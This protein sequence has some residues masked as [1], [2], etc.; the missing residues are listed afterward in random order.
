MVRVRPETREDEAGVR[1]RNLAAFPTAQEADLVEAL[2]RDGDCALG[3]PDYYRRFGFSVEAA[4][5]FAS[6]YA[7]PYFQAL[8]LA[9]DAP[10]A[11]RVS[12]PAAFDGL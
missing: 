9:P 7:G 8:M 2:R 10:K 1:E 5:A 3:E 4:G 11:G 12:Y 6:P